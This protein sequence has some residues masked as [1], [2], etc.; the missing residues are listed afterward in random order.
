MSRDGRYAAR[1][2]GWRCGDPSRR[3]RYAARSQGWRCG[4]P[5]RRGRYAARSQGWRCGD[6]S[7]DGRYAARSQGWRCGAP[8]R[9]GRY[10]AKNQV[11]RCSDPDVMQKPLCQDHPTALWELSYWRLPEPAISCSHRIRSAQGSAQWQG[12]H[13]DRMSYSSCDPRPW[14]TDVARVLF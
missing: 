14:S 6:P 5:S 10:A 2:Q 9:D 8:S 3:G 13:Q 11:W 7:R 1:S 12:R 4:D